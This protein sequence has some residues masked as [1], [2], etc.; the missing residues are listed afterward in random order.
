MLHIY[1]NSRFGATRGIPKI[2]S[3]MT[4]IKW[5]SDYQYSELVSSKASA[6]KMGF[7]TSPT[8]EGYADSYLNGDEYQPAMEFSPGTF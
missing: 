1:Q 6:S 4:M 7:I 5:L 8:G 2:T 3:V